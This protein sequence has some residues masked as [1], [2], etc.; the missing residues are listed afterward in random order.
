MWSSRG[1]QKSR[2]RKVTHNHN[3]DADKE[4]KPIMKER[5]GRGLGRWALICLIA[6]SLVGCQANKSFKAGRHY[7]KKQ[8]WDKA[9]LHY[10]R[11]VELNPG[12]LEYEM[13]LERARI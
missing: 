11:A 5:K 8:D 12:Q 6:V 9:V 7:A 10:D 2:W 13:A 3:A 1:R 4:L